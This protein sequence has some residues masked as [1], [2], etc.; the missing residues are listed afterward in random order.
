[1]NEPG[2]QGDGDQSLAE[3]LF[4]EPLK[5]LEERQM[6]EQAART[7]LQWLSRK[8]ATVEG[9]SSAQKKTRARAKVVRIG[10]RSG[11]IFFVVKR[12]EHMLEPVQAKL[13]KVHLTPQQ[14]SGPEFLNY[15]PAVALVVR[16]D[17]TLDQLLEHGDKALEEIYNVDRAMRAEK[18]R[19]TA[20]DGIDIKEEGFGEFPESV[21]E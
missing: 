9:E 13:K 19:I 12:S 4:A 21:M 20:K 5:K 14:T 8:E 18:S 10:L 1:M 7:V 15:R 16:D 3:V 11:D 17:A 6:R 2:E